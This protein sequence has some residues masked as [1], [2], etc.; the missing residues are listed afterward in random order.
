MSQYRDDQE[1]ARHRLESLEEKL[2][3]RDAELELHKNEIAER[4][5]EISRLSHELRSAGTTRITM[6]R[7][8]SGARFMVAGAMSAVL[9][10]GLLGFVSPSIARAP[11]PPWSRSP[12]SHLRRCRSPRLAST[13]RPR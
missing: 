8:T 6:P 10:A 1:A 3:E 12:S 2:A 9:V 13:S 7:R 11:R 5:R 4:D